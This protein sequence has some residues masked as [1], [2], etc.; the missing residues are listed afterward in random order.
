M[1]LLILVVGSLTGYFWWHHERSECKKR[2]NAY[3][4]RVEDL[5]RKAHQQLQ[6]G[7]EKSQ[8]IKF[9][10]A[11]G[12][13]ISFIEGEATGTIYTTGCSPFGCGTDEALLGLRVKVD[14]KGTVISEPQIGAL[15]TNCL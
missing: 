1:L 3:D 6:I 2:G 15:Y 5:K 13:P 10:Q 11:N 4:T 8:V 9:F 12:I 7:T 14:G